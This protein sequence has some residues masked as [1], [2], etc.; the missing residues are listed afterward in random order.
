L[1]AIIAGCGSA[2]FVLA[3]VTWAVPTLAEAPAV[4]PVLIIRHIVSALV[5]VKGRRSRSGEVLG[6]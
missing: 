3:T 6:L 1:E 4:A 2:L 5:V